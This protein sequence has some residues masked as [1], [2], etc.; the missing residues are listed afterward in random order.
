MNFLRSGA[1]LPERILVPVNYV[2][3]VTNNLR[4]N[5]PLGAFPYILRVIKNQWSTCCNKNIGRRMFCMVSVHNSCVSSLTYCILD[6]PPPPPPPPQGACFI[7]DF[8]LQFKF[9]GNCD[10]TWMTTPETC[11]LLRVPET[12]ETRFKVEVVYKLT[13]VVFLD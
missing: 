6:S 10:E 13:T 4:G 9:H 5:L 1:G 3:P 12:T 2:V 7:D 8:C 11:D